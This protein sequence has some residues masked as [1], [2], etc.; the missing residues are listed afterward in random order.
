MECT[1]AAPRRLRQLVAQLVAPTLAVS[2]ADTRVLSQ[3]PVRSGSAGAGSGPLAGVRILDMSSVIAGPWGVALLAD[4]GADV[5]KLESPGSPDMT[6]GLGAAPAPGLG[7]MYITANRGK[8]SITLDVNRPE[9]VAALKRLVAKTDVVV[10]NYRPGVAQRLGVDY[11][12]LSAV[13]PELIMLCIT[14]YGESG[15]YVDAKVYDQ[16]VQAMAGLPSVTSEDPAGGNI[17]PNAVVDK[18]TALHAA[19]GITAALLVRAKGGGGQLIQLSMLDAA[20]HFLYP[21]AYWNKTWTKAKPFPMEWRN[22]AVNCEFQVA[23][24]KMAIAATDKKQFQGLLEVTG[25]QQFKSESLGEM[26][27]KA[28]GQVT[29]TLRSMKR[30]EIFASC[31]KHGVPCGKFQTKDEVL[32]DPQV[33]HNNT[34]QEH[35]HPDG[36]S[37]LTPKSPAAFARTPSTAVPRPAPRMGADTVQVLEEFGFSRAEV[38]ELKGAKVIG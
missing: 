24:G 18:V 5:I 26:R 6:R 25:L 19:Q 7:A 30:E 17:F 11:Q 27:A 14:G 15:P 37:Y 33:R 36:G 3:C 38:D 31:L 32:Q 20:V 22:I 4:Q 8:R 34:V 1:A 21:D 13:N 12:A 9:G 35:V 29:K 10:Q 2:E 28:M 16:A 23:D